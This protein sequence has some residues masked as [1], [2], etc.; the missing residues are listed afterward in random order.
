[1]QF[2]LQIAQTKKLIALEWGFFFKSNGNEEV[3]T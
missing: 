3:S 2:L 1:M